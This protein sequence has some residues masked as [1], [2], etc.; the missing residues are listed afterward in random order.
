MYWRGFSRR[1]WVEWT[2]PKWGGGQV[3][4]SG[5]VKRSVGNG[6]DIYE[7]S[8]NWERSELAFKVLPSLSQTN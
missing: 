4:V 1:N 5:H 2:L 3:G 6:G 7:Q 8:N